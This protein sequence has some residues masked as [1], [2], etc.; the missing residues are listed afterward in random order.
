MKLRLALIPVLVMYTVLSS[1]QNTVRIQSPD[2]NLSMTMSAEKGGVTYR[3][4]YKKENVFKDSG[5]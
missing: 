1:A 5:I 4:D 2:G 3:I